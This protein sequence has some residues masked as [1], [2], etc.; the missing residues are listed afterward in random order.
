[1]V[2][3]VCASKVSQ[4]RR[5]ALLARLFPPLATFETRLMFD[6]LLA[7]NHHRAH[8]PRIIGMMCVFLVTLYFVNAVFCDIYAV[9]CQQP[10]RHVL[11]HPWKNDRV[12]S[13]GMDC[14]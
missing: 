13:L 7:I 6:Q 8:D 2:K 9:I 1:M 12:T 5:V 11:H 10:R 3:V 14:L 4:V